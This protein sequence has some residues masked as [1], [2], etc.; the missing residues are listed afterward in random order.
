MIT[1]RKFVQTS[2]AASALALAGCDKEPQKPP[3]PPVGPAANAEL[4]LSFFGG[5]VFVPDTADVIL[6]VYP[7]GTGAYHEQFPLEHKGY[8]AGP[9]F[10]GPALPVRFAAKGVG[11]AGESTECL[12][13]KTVTVTGR[14][15][16]PKAK[17]KCAKLADYTGLVDG[18]T[19]T[20]DW[21]PSTD[22][23]INSIFR[24][25]DGDLIDGDKSINQHGGNATW[26]IKK[27]NAKGLCDVAILDLKSPDGITISGLDKDITISPGKK[28][29]LG[30][31]AG[32][33]H[34]HD[35]P[36]KYTKISH[37]VLL[38]TI[39]EVPKGTSDD[40]IMPTSDSEVEG[41]YGDEM[42][43]PCKKGQKIRVPPDS[44]YCPNYGG[45]P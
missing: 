37:A 18:W 10:S 7:S 21:K 26:R 3:E 33:L 16:N 23:N 30:V 40:D 27:G 19:R 24:L 45:T 14:K 11:F 32:P 12:V 36:Y 2:L 41:E 17:N 29:E 4:R 15:Q 42:E 13:G 1:R 20:K 25:L 43:N 9:G 5:A 34:L 28:L 39:Y 35:E 8:I 6:A 44:E 31:F 38:R 22:G